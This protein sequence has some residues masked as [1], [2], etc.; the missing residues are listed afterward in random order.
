[1]LKAAV[2][3][4]RGSVRLLEV[5]TPNIGPGEVLVRMKACGICGTDLEK[6]H[7]D[8]ITPPILGHEVAGVVEQ[9]GAS[10]DSFAVGDRVAVHH[11]VSCRRCYFCK[12]GFETLCDEYP[13]SNLDPCGFAESFRVPD[14]LVRGGT[15]HRLPDSMTYEEGSQAEPL[16]CCIRALNKMQVKSGSSVAIFGVGPVGLSHLQ[17][18]KCFGA[19]R[20]YAIDVIKKRREHA[21]KMGADLAFDPTTDDAPKTISL[22]TGG[23]GVDLAIVATA[24]LKALESAFETVRKGGTVLQFGAP[25]RGSLYTLDMGRMF[26]REVRFQSSYSTS[27]TEMEMALELIES[28]RVKPSEIITDR[29]PLSRT[30]EALAL[31]DRAADALKVI[32]ENQ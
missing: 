25:T 19:S 3:A 6:V 20:V 13:K 28:K 16:A 4:G 8:Q 30:V 12:N 21:V 31:A 26:L 2:I 10:I 14:V 22:L 32:V 24:N 11:H 9:V 1:M 18:L 15:V 7:G 29:L 17:L 5:P 23:I 27:E